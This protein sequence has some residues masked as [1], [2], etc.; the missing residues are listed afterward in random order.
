MQ[1]FRDLFGEETLRPG[2]EVG[3]DQVTLMFTDLKGSTALYSRLGDAPAYGLV[4]EHFAVLTGV[5][6]RND[7][8]IVKTI[9][10]AVMAAFADPA[11]AVRAALEMHHAVIEFNERTGWDAIVLKLGIHAGPCIAVTL[12]D[13]LDYFGTTV[14]LAARLQ[15]RSEGEDLVLSAN[16]IDDPAVAPLVEGLPL[17]AEMARIKGFDKP[18]SYLRLRFRSRETSA[19]SEAKGAVRTIG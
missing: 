3:I 11:D 6:R 19:P 9:G 10:D 4:R 7:G 13:R 12:N 14:N 5:V 17:G 18:V 15:D 1:S 16:L 2:D 8:A